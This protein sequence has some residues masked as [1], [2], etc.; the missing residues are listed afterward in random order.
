M[1]KNG[2]AS[3]KFYKVVG[4]SFVLKTKQEFEEAENK[5]LEEPKTFRKIGKLEDMV[6][7]YSHSKFRKQGNFYFNQKFQSFPIFKI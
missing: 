7:Y 5:K 3:E 2:K 4:S 6:N 1:I